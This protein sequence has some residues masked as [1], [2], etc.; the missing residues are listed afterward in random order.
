MGFMRRFTFGVLLLFPLL[1]LPASAATTPLDFTV[2]AGKHDRVETPVT[3]SVLLPASLSKIKT[4]TLKD[5]KGRSVVAQLTK[6]ALLAKNI[7]ASKSQVAREVHFILPSLKAGQSLKFQGV[8]DADKPE[9]AAKNVFSW[10]DKPGES[11]ELDYKGVPALRYMDHPIDE[12]T[13]AKR[14]ETYKVYDHLFD[15]EGNR[16]TKGPGGLYPHHRGIFYG[17]RVVTY[18]DGKKTDIWHC[19]KASQQHEKILETEAGPVL[20]R[21]RVLIGWHG[22]DKKIFAQE[23]RELT[24]YAVPGGRLVEFAS[25]LRPVKGKVHLDGDPQHAGFHFRADQG[26]AA[27]SE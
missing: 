23:E 8:I 10:H 13:K 26:V 3:V 21:E 24:V 15:L 27:D 25:R 9:V 5:D 1:A 7:E 16:V 11:S 6:P 4:I 18:D 20:G 12:S 2:A 14:D 19:P 22:D 17:F